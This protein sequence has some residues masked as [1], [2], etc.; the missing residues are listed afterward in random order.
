MGIHWEMFR[1]IDQIQIDCTASQMNRENFFFFFTA[2]FTTALLQEVWCLSL[3]HCWF[4][5]MGY[6]NCMAP[7]WVGSGWWSELKT[8]PRGKPNWF[9]L[10][11]WLSDSLHALSTGGKEE[12]GKWGQAQCEM[13]G[14][15]HD[16][17]FFGS[18]LTMK[19]VGLLLIG[20]GFFGCCFLS[21][22]LLI[23]S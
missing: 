20:W 8:N 9:Q 5:W 12:V 21:S 6:S 1:K 14:V 23:F 13:Y 7:W 11:Q 15:R 22:V 10:D 2:Y 4:L 3:P 17:P 18:Y 19:T 16:Q